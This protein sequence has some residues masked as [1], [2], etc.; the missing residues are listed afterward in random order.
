M[1][2]CPVNCR[3]CW[4]PTL[5]S[6]K[7]DPARLSDDFFFVGIFLLLLQ[8]MVGIIVSELISNTFLTTG[9]LYFG[10][11]DSRGD[12]GWLALWMSDASPEIFWELKSMLTSP[13]CCLSRSIRV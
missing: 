11:L 3:L 2:K 8:F 6:P 1:P 9:T 12:E 13:G 7:S 4:N 10:D 5:A